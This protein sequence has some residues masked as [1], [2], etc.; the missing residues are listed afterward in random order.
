MRKVTHRQK[1]V[2]EYKEKNE[3]RAKETRESANI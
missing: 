3:H 1:E 2:R